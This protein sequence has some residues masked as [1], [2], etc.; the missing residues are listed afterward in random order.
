MRKWKAAQDAQLGISRGLVLPLPSGNG[1]HDA[2]F[3]GTAI[4]IPS[5]LVPKPITSPSSL[6]S[7]SQLNAQKTLRQDS[8]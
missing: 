6:S 8:G 1:Q 4:S 7:P 3:A 5:H 2:V